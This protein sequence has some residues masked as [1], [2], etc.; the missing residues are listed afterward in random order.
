MK[1]P[2]SPRGEQ[3]ST[4]PVQDRSNKDEIAR[5]HIQDQML[6]TNMGGPLPEQ[7][8]PGKIHSILDV[9]CGTGDW[10]LET[11]RTY[12]EI[13]RLI[14]VDISG[15]MI[16]LAREQA[17]EQHM[18]DRVEFHVMDALRKL[19]FP[20][21]YFDLVNQRLGMSYLRTWDWPN[22]LQEYRRVTRP[23][24]I[25]RISELRTTVET[26]SA[27]QARIGD[28]MLQAF[29]QAG[30][31]FVPSGEGSIG[32]TDHLV[33]LLHQ[34]G[35]QNIQTRLHRIE[36]RADTPTGQ[37]FIEDMAR[38]FR[39]NVPFLRKWTRVPDD[40]E[41]IYQQMLREMHQ[42]DFVA[43]WHLLTVWANA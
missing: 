38:L 35:Y 39:T 26:T 29:V 15:K 14:G 10:L 8:E 36:F 12:P 34:R 19:E 33:P 5:L 22:L 30:H 13:T 43:A 11:A 2:N 3:A 37:M 1:N 41:T 6:T 17:R 28:I 24:G 7:P 32:V 40:Y 42:P 16:G 23:G 18:T 4:Y 31:Y 20:D 9:A 27:A 21:H 25:V